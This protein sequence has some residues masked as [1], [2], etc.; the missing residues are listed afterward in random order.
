MKLKLLCD[1]K[2]KI[3]AAHRRDSQPRL[4]PGNANANSAIAIS[5]TAPKKGHHFHEVTVPNNWHE[6]VVNGNLAKRLFEHKIEVVN[7]EP[8]LKPLA[9]RK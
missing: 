8:I 6:D 2:G 4:Q 9:K 1:A 3:I 5:E 7:K